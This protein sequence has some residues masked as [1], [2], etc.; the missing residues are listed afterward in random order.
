M[1]LRYGI[2]TVETT[3]KAVINRFKAMMNAKERINGEQISEM[4]MHMATTLGA[5]HHCKAVVVV[6]D[7]IRDKWFVAVDDD[8]PP[9]EFASIGMQ[10]AKDGQSLLMATKPQGSC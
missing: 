7:E 2:H 9:S 3:E 4:L 8:I 5:L 1:P 10:L 6:S